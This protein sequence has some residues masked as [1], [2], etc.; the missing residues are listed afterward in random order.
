MRLT[1][2]SGK[3]RAAMNNVSRTIAETQELGGGRGIARLQVGEPLN[4]TRPRL[5]TRKF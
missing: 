1:G 3:K 5:V 4:Q 2:Q